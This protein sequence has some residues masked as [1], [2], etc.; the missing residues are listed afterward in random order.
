[1]KQLIG[2]INAVTGLLLG[3]AVWVAV[4]AFVLR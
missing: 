4:A 2:L 3:L 1:M